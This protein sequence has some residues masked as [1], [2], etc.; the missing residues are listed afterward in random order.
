MNYF[1]HHQHH[2]YDPSSQSQE[3]HDQSTNNYYSFSYSYPNPQFSSSINPYSYQNPIA[4]PSQHE[5]QEPNPPGVTPLPDL[6]R[7][8]YY[9]YHA[10]GAAAGVPTVGT[11]PGAV[12]HQPVCI[13]FLIFFMLLL[14]DFVFIIQEIIYFFGCLVCMMCSQSNC[15]FLVYCEMGVWISLFFSADVRCDIEV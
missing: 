10:H 13:L 11:Q 12:V 5:E 14:L 6:S 3:S 2:E 8:P 7:N 1:V 4:Q 15:Y 9:Q